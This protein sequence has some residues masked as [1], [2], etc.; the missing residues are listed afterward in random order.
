VVI[1]VNAFLGVVGRGRGKASGYF[2]RAH[3]EPQLGGGGV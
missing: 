2:P 3:V 1:Q